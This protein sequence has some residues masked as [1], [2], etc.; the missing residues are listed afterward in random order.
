MSSSDSL[1]G[2]VSDVLRFACITHAKALDGLGQD[3]GRLTLV[4]EAA[5]RQ[6]RP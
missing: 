5:C 4:I 2:L 3:Q 6:Q 1:L